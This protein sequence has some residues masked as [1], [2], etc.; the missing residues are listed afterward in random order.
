MARA[1]VRQRS[2]SGD[3]GREEEGAKGR[4]ERWDA[5]RVAELEWVNGEEDG[6]TF[7]YQHSTP[8]RRGLANL[9]NKSATSW[10]LSWSPLG[11][12]P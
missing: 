11:S 3:E 4:E 1:Q 8:Q 7:A 12:V 6:V 9:T 2:G 5:M 10:P